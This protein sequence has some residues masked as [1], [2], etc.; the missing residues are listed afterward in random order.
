[1][2]KLSD[3][4]LVEQLD[5]VGLK[6]VAAGVLGIG[7]DVIKDLRIHK[8]SVDA[9]RKPE[10]RFVYTLLVKA[11]NERAVLNRNIPNVTAHIQTETY[12]FPAIGRVNTGQPP[13]VVGMGPAGLFSALYLAE[14]GIKCVVLE[15]GSPVERRV[16][17]VARFWHSGRLDLS[18]NVQFGEGGAG[19]FSDGK[20]T[21]GVGDIRKRF[22]LE[23]LVRFGAPESILYLAK[24]HI[25]TDL[26]RDIV[27]AV[28]S[29]LFQ[30]GCDIRFG[31]KLND[32]DISGGALRGLEVREGSYEYEMEADKLILAPGNSARDTFEML[33]RRGVMLT[34]KDFSVGVRIE[35]SQRSIDKSQYG[36][37]AIS[38]GY[39][40]PAADYKLVAHIDGNRSVYTFCVCPGGQVVAAASEKGGVVTN[41][42]SKYARDGENCSG[43]LL[44]NVTPEDFGCGPLDGVE[45]QRN[46]ERAAFISGGGAYLAPAQLVCDFLEKCAS[47]GC[48]N[49]TPT[50]QPGVKY[51]NLWDVLPEFVC[52]AIR[53]ALPEFE[54][55]VEG[56]ADPGAVLTAVETRSSSPVRVL[57]ENYETVGIKGIFPCGEGS[58]YAGGIMSS[59]IDGIKCAERALSSL[60]S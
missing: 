25:G 21:T 24:P 5:T 36:G 60:Y 37:A 40:L 33:S 45:F 12:G 46:L 22:I 28:R 47:T 53:A 54:K 48:K 59:A 49:I 23:Q 42:M 10:V 20:L 3:I 9:R 39:K 35:H 56:F 52:G 7:E 17:D 57:R 14:A 27:K 41:G 30:L 26:L 6:Q 50:Y 18:S 2:L 51:C 31:H 16:G 15:R 44:V 55:R 58:G 8:L 29:R 19:T 32:L 11:D 43:A 4:R 34:P 13:V 1:M 38:S